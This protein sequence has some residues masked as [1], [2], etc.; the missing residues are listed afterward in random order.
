MLVVLVAE[1]LLVLVD[2]A[3]VAAVDTA[4]KGLQPFFKAMLVGRRLAFHREL[5]AA[6]LVQQEQIQQQA[7]VTERL[8]AMDTHLQSLE[9][10]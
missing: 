3:A 1:P 5:V 6:E 4:Q 7:A 10:Q 8:A 9:R 2:Q